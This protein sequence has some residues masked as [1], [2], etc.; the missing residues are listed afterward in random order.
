MEQ[1]KF[2]FE[3]FKRDAIEKLRNKQPLTGKDGVLQP[4]IKQILEAALEAEMDAHLDENERAEGNRKNGKLRKTVKSSK[5]QFEL[6][7]PRDRLGT[8]DPQIVGKRQTLISEEIEEK[9]IRLYSKGLGVREICDH[10]EEM[11]GFTLSPTTLSAITDRV[12]PLVKEWQQRPLENHYCFVW[13]DALHYK[14]REDGKVITKAVY[15][16]IGVNSEGVKELIGLY[17]AESEGARFWLQVMED[18]RRRGVE[19]ILIACIDNLSGFTEAIAEVFPKTEIQTC[20]IHQIRNTFKYVASK[21]SRAFMDDLKPVYQAADKTIAEENLDA[22]EARW[23]NKYRVAINS[24]RNNWQHLS[25]F[26]RFPEEIRRVMYTTNIIEG[27]H[28]QVRKVTKTKGAFTSDM[29]LLKLIYLATMNLVE[30]WSVPIHNWATIASQ[31]KIIFG[32]RAKIGINR[33]RLAS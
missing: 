3:A 8:F 31:L 25:T 7:T 32:D 15:N 21:D 12:I 4:L 17:L 22:M 30:K 26:F 18:L 2:D 14:V 1:E 10:I 33:G 9:V 28:R 19:D 27:F 13:M 5:G 11:Y 29:A 24:W 20:V 6:E 23:G 16:I